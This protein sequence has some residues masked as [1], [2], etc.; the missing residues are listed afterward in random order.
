MPCS[1]ELENGWIEKKEK[2]KEE[3]EVITDTKRWQSVYCVFKIKFI[4]INKMEWLCAEAIYENLFYNVQ[5]VFDPFEIVC[6][7][8]IWV[9]ISGRSSRLGI[10]MFAETKRRNKKHKSLKSKNPTT[11]KRNLFPCIYA[12]I[13]TN[14]THSHST[15]Q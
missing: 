4:W 12:Y 3:E 6:S 2:E 7:R 15:I 11:I 14:L 1:I 8:T 9:D 10:P 5:H 13:Y